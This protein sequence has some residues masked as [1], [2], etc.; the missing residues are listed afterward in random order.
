MLPIA[1]RAQEVPDEPVGAEI[2][3]DMSFFD[4]D[5][6]GD[7]EAGRVFRQLVMAKINACSYSNAAR[8][9]FQ[10][11]IFKTAE[12]FATALL[13][14]RAEGRLDQLKGPPA[15]EEEKINPHGGPK[16]CKEYREMPSYLERRERLMRY[17]KSEISIDEALGDSDCP[18]GPATL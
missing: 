10:A 9:R 6:C 15:I 13:Q 3:Y 14:A 17:A 16:S 12:G 1:A 4:F 5:V 7:A 8:E 18:K 11:H 2:A